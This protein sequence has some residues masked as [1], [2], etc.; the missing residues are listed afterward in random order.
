MTVEPGAN[1]VIPH[2]VTFNLDIRSGDDDALGERLARVITL[3]EQ[4]A[5][6]E[7]VE[8]G[9]EQTWAM[10][11]PP[12]DSSVRQLL[13]RVADE[14]GVR[15]SQVRG[16]IGHDSLHLSSMGPAAMIF[17]RTRDGLSHCEEEFA[18]WESVLATAGV[19]A[20]AALALADAQHLTDLGV[21]VDS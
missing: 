4:I 21:D 12:F 5:R 15:W 16:R 17:T 8:V 10:S 3:F 14:R 20:N 11:G 9:V 18:P 1:N 7:G 19:Y 2:R 6:Q 13:E